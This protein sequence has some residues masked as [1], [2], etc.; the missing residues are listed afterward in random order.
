MGG[1]A[2]TL[3]NIYKK[4]KETEAKELLIIKDSYTKFQFIN[5]F[6]SFI[7]IN[8][9]ILYLVYTNEQ[10]SLIFYNLIDNIKMNEIKNC[11]ATNINNIRYFFD[12]INN[13][14]LILSISF[15]NLKTWNINSECI[16][17]INE[18]SILTACI[19]NNNNQNYIISI[20]KNLISHIWNRA[21]KTY[22][23]DGILVKE[24]DLEPIFGL[25][26]IPSEGFI[27]YYYD[28]N[29]SKNFI[30]LCNDYSSFSFDYNEQRIYQEYKEYYYYNKHELYAYIIKDEKN[31]VKLI[32]SI[33]AGRINIWD[34]HSGEFLFAIHDKENYFLYDICL[35]KENYLFIGCSNNTIKLL[36]LNDGKIIYEFKTYKYSVISIKI[37]NHPKYGECLLSHGY[38]SGGIQLWDIKYILIDNDNI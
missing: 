25:N 20:T 9:G 31:I 4:K 15:G 14:D 30:I 12:K 11:H 17:N 5:I 35:W 19:L 34:F 28:I 32:E 24:I 38:L 18:K 37:I 29:Y 13:R 16:I 23:L 36:D 27:D 2:S 8:N 6:A 33:K 10:K 21:M 22:N 3:E 7:S 1:K 26:D